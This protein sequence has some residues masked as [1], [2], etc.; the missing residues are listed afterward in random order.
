MQLTLRTM[1][2]NRE[3]SPVK[4][5]SDLTQI[6]TQV[7]G[8]HFSNSAHLDPRENMHCGNLVGLFSGSRLSCSVEIDLEV[9][10]LL[11]RNVRKD[12]LP[13][14][15]QLFTKS[16]A[17]ALVDWGVCLFGSSDL[18][19]HGVIGLH[20]TMLIKIVSANSFINIG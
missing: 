9:R 14:Q 7:S 8:P 3:L 5:L 20:Q 11:R 15:L 16:A 4:L 17:Q 1:W 18:D 2:F 19:T 13:T 12:H 6:G 10:R